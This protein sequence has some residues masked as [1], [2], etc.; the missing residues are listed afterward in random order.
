M[1]DT[2]LNKGIIESRKDGIMSNNKKAD[3]HGLT[4]LA[5][6]FLT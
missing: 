4:N 1:E 3:N 6:N 5:S 2:A